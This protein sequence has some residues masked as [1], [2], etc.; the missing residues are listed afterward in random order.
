MSDSEK[1]VR[2]F[3]VNLRRRNVR[4]AHIGAQKGQFGVEVFTS[5]QHNG[6]MHI[7]LSPACPDVAG[8]RFFG[9][10]NQTAHG[11]GNDRRFSEAQIPSF[12]SKWSSLSEFVK[13]I[14]QE[15]S[16]FYNKRHGRRGFFWG[17]RFKSVIVENLLEMRDPRGDLWMFAYD[18]KA[19]P[20]TK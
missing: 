18:A 20:K 15:F 13:E 5:S 2:R 17:D 11:Y 10:G 8:E 6:V 1:F 9:C 12:R 7:T 4:M 3:Q 19:Q 16:R 14:K